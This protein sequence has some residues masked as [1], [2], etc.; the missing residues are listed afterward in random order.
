MLI[1]LSI[2]LR[3]QVNSCDCLCRAAH[4]ET[5]LL[6]GGTSSLASWDYTSNTQTKLLLTQS[7]IICI[8][9]SMSLPATV[10]V[11]TEDGILYL[12][13]AASGSNRKLK[14]EAPACDVRFDP[15]STSYMLV[16]LK[17]GQM[18]LYELQDLQQVQ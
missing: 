10:A 15:L 14:L 8:S 2:N 11:A 12:V 18:C 9:Q 7:T 13:D 4:H 1:Y 6:L 5:T 3:F 16:L 17:Q